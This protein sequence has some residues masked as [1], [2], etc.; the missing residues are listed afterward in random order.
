[1]GA[2]EF[3]KVA[4]GILA[5][6]AFVPLVIEAI[7]DHGA[8]QSFATWI[9][10]AALDWVLTASIIQQDGNYLMPLGFALGDA[11]MVVILLKQRRFIWG[12][13]ET[14]V[15]L[16]VLFCV[17]IWQSAGPR[18]GTIAAITGIC[19]AGIP[20]LIELW[21]TAERRVGNVWALCAIANCVSY[22]GGSSMSV[23][24]RLAPGVFAVFSVLMFTASRRR[25]P[26][27]RSNAKPI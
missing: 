22:L 23:E 21:K 7:R 6:V 3:F 16:A 24:E 2:N 10:W 9:L 18:L 19:V 1:M 27:A 8:G 11:L 17:G 26:D 12:R 20:G 4:G 13:F 15:L 25:L 5:L 14:V